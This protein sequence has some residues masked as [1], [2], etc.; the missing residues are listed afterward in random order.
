[1]TFCCASVWCC[2]MTDGS[3]SFSTYFWTFTPL[4]PPIGTG[5]RLL[6]KSVKSIYSSN[7]ETC[8]V[9]TAGHVNFPAHVLTRP[10]KVS[11][12]LH[13]SCGITI[14]KAW[15]I[16]GFGFLL[17]VMIVSGVGLTVLAS[18]LFWLSIEISAWS[19]NKSCSC[20]II[21]FSVIIS[22]YLLSIW[23]KTSFHSVTARFA[24][25]STKLFAF[26]SQMSCWSESSP[27]LQCALVLTTLIHPFG[28]AATCSQIK[29]QMSQW[30]SILGDWSCW[31]ASKSS[32]SCVTTDW[33]SE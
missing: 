21:L 28:R 29:F 15:H 27:G 33:Q 1:M 16:R 5:Q 25:S 30:S 31:C 14:W 7:K 10:I 3:K 20:F 19:N 11:P 2:V 22:L 23:G 13:G 8:P 17:V 26:A 32:L 9:V 24:I 12:N 18:L 4:L 6:A